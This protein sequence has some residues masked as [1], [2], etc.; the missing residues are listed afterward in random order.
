MNFEAIFKHKNRDAG[1]KPSIPKFLCNI[2][3]KRFLYLLEAILADTLA[4]EEN[5]IVCISAEYAG[6]L[7]FLK[8]DSVFIGE[9]FK[10]VLLSDIQCLADAYGEHYAAKL[11]YFSYDSG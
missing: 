2:Y 8:N 7:V 9:N 4:V 3:L 1:R 5:Y 11:I 6:G 10:R